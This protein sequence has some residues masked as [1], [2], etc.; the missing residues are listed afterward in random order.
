VASALI[1]A[2]VSDGPILV[3][4]DHTLERRR[5]PCIGPASRYCDATRSSKRTSRHLFGKQRFCIGPLG[6]KSP[7]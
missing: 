2:F 6:V 5:G 1:A 4:I 7:E 3:G